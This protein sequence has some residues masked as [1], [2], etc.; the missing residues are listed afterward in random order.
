[1]QK[2]PSESAPTYLTHRYWTEEEAGQALAAL[3]KSGLTLGAFAAR[4]GLDPRRLARWRRRL[5]VDAESTTFEEVPSRATR[6][7]LG[8][9]A[10]PVEVGE[11]FEVVLPSGCVVRVPGSFD[12]SALRR[13]L[14]VVVEEVGKC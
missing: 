5:A 2:P 10:A 4:V 8:G 6:G 11:R 3:E 14:S 7:I 9:G 12:A 13:L 1:M